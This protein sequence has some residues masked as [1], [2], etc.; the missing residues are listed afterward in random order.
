MIYLSDQAP[1]HAVYDIVIVD[2]L[3]P[4]I[5]GIRIVDAAHSA[6]PSAPQDAD[7]FDLSDTPLPL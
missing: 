4:I 2:D 1:H 6:P 7:D 3:A 5:L